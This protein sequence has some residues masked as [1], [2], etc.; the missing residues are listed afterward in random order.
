MAGES[1]RITVGYDTVTPVP[2]AVMS[3]DVFDSMGNIVHGVNTDA[4]GL[5][6]PPLSGR[7]IVVFDL[8]YVPLL[9]GDYPFAISLLS[10]SGAYR[11]DWTEPEKNSFRVVSSGHMTGSVALP[12][13]AHHVA[14]VG[15]STI[16]L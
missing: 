8:D 6:L 2:D 13:R 12:I 15:A 16:P 1:L 5:H 3:I 4:L 14:G 9:D 10:R 11:L 7:G